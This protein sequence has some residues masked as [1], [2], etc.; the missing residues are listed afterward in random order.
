MIRIIPLLTIAIVSISSFAFG[1]G[2]D[3]KPGDLHRQSAWPDGVYK[4]VNQQYR[5]H[6]YWINSVDKLFYR[7]GHAE[8]HKMIADLAKS[9]DTNMKVILH[10]GR[11]SAKS[12]WSKGPVARADWAITI[13]S[14]FSN[15]HR[16]CDI[17]IDVWL[18]DLDLD[19]LKIPTSI[20]VESGGEIDTFIRKHRSKLSE[21]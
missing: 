9:S 3:H 15:A 4:A 17:T 11:G 16:Q 2:S 19:D 14:A 7:A 6:G 21:N 12:P 10:A 5:V 8:L 1:M 13:E 20:P 18:S